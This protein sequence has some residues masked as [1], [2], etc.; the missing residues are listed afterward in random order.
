MTSVVYEVAACLP[1]LVAVRG[2]SVQP[3]QIIYVDKVRKFLE[4]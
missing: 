4:E 2:T 3:K 1:L